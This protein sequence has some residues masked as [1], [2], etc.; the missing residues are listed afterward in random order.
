MTDAY[1][2]S[3][4]DEKKTEKESSSKSGMQNMGKFVWTVLLFIGLVVVFFLFGGFILFGCK[5]GQ[6]N[7]LPTAYHCFPYTDVNPEI[8][9]I[10]TNIFTTFTEPKLSMKMIFPQDKY[11]LSSFLLDVFREYKQQPTS[12]FLTNYF[13]SII[14]SLVHNNYS[15]LNIFFNALNGLPEYLI[16]LLGPI[17]FSIAL[18]CLFLFDHI[19]ILY[20]WFANMGW[21]FK[22]NTNT[23]TNGKPKWTEVTFT[24]PLNYMSSI[25]FVILFCILVWVLLGILPVLPFLTLA[26]CTLSCFAYK[27]DMNGDHITVLSVIQNVFKYYKTTF[28]TIV[29]V[30]VTI[31]AFGNLGTIPGI[32]SI[33]V[34]LLMYWGTISIDI[35]HSIQP[36]HL[37]KLSSYEQAKKICNMKQPLKETHGFLYNLLFGQNG[38]GNIAKELKRIHKSIKSI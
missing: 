5:L 29:G 35:F 10:Q 36:D 19:Y 24:Q 1:D 6:S 27:A 33:L 13:I 14:E 31:S 17:L 23:D 20:L 15:Y 34:L 26:L 9:S 7:I 32:F 2:T 38:G 30:F 16:V 8:Q 28:M 37:S 18:S 12:H 25:G 4:I 3:T 11:N 21:F 22:Q